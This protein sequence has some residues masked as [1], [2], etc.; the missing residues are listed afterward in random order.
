MK[1]IFEKEGNTIFI[2][3][4]GEI[5]T[6]LK[7]FEKI[8]YIVNENLGVTTEVTTGLDYSY[9]GEPFEFIGIANNRIYLRHKNGFLNNKVI[10]LSIDN[11]SENWGYFE[12]LEGIKMNDL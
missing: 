12:L 8:S 3:N 10:H 11:C 1:E 4:K 2:F 7:P 9:V 5:I 6:R